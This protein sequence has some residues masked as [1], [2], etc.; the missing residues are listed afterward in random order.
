MADLYLL[1]A[2][3]LNEYLDA[4]TEEVWEYVNLVRDRA[5]LESV[6][7]AWTNYAKIDDKYT[8]K[9]GMRDIIRRE[10]SIELMFEGHRFFDLRRWNMATSELT[11]FVR[12][13]NIMG[14]AP[15]DFYQVVTIDDVVFTDRDVLTPIRTGELIK[16]RNLI[17]NPG[18]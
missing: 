12:G 11:G 17:Q 6:Q 14:S 15:E 9:E 16:N 7:D 5:G 18:W 1:Y 2:E 4:P 3:A 10:R 13:W 8:K